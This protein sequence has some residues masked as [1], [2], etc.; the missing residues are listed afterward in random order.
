MEMDVLPVVGVFVHAEQRAQ[1]L[2]SALVTTLLDSLISS[3][4]VQPGDAV[5]NSTWRWPRYDKLISDCGLRSLP[6]K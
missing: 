5:F 4:V 2:G 1:G 6:W 3:G